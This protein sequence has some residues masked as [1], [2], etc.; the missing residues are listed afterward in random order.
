MQLDRSCSDDAILDRWRHNWRR[1]HEIRTIL[2]TKVAVTP[3]VV[4]AVVTTD[5]SA[6]V[7]G[8]RG[9]CLTSHDRYRDRCCWPKTPRG[10]DVS[11]GSP[12]KDSF[13]EGREAA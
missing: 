3:D 9:R 8:G 6:R 7:G 4:L 10:L 5:T 13:I 11:R 1:N 2:L 12:L